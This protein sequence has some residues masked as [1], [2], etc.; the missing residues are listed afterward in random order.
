MVDL[1]EGCFLIIQYT[2]KNRWELE[3]WLKIHGYTGTPDKP[4]IAY[5]LGS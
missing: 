3:T 4:K 2:N 5:E 1:I